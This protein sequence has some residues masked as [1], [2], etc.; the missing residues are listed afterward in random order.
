MSYVRA[1]EILPED[2][3]KAIQRYVSG[4][5]VYIPCR[6]KKDWGSQTKTRQYY[7]SRNAK[8][9]RERESGVP[10]RALADE[11]ALS[12]KSVQRIIRAAKKSP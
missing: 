6:E 12:E 5:S 7:Q 1:D 2:L 8:I 9:V 3:I 10:V 11:F 4:R